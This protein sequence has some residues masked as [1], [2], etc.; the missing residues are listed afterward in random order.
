MKKF[1]PNYDE[2]MWKGAPE[3][4]FVKAKALRKDETQAEKILWAKLRNNQLKGYKFRRQH[5]IGLYIVDF[6]CHQLKLVIEIDGDYHNIQEQ[7]EKDKERTQNLE[8]DGLQLIR[9]TNKDVME[10]LEK[11]ISEIMIKTDEIFHSHN[12]NQ[13]L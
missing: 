6:Y 4:S 1:K 9:F 2:G 11:I 7:I 10:N 5:P 12:S 8:T 3:S 13:S